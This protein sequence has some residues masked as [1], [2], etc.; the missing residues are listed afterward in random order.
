M[1]APVFA[2]A[3]NSLINQRFTAA[4]TVLSIALSITLLI[5]VERLRN[6]ARASFANTISGT[7]LMVGARSGPV[8]LL[9]YAVFRIGDTT[10]NISWASYQ[11]IT[12]HPSVAWT[13]PLTLGD[14]HRG[15]RVLGTTAGYFEHYRFARDRGLD[16]TAG[17]P[18]H[19]LYDAVVGAEV[20]ES[21]G[22][23]PGDP[24]VVAHGA[25]D[26][27][28]VIPN[29]RRVT[30]SGPFWGA[31]RRDGAIFPQLC[32]APRLCSLLHSARYA[33][34]CEKMASGNTLRI[35][36]NRP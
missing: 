3:W 29:E 31:T 16:F 7:D 1:K 30:P 25:S 6:E 11:E 10:N 5:G 26:V 28:L 4:L 12:R 21:L 32:V 20:A 24:I 23:R 2:L 19:D 35:S 14:S 27:S 33:L 22:Y 17:R 13:V 18:F 9:L 36:V 8:Q 34:I 15:F